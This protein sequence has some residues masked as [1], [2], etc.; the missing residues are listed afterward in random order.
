MQIPFGLYPLSRRYLIDLSARPHRNVATEKLVVQMVNIC[1]SLNSVLPCRVHRGDQCAVWCSIF[2]EPSPV[3]RPHGQD[4][5]CRRH[6]SSYVSQ[7]KAFPHPALTLHL[8]TR[9]V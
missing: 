2:R 7:H 5:P 4:I 3:G 1:V 8:Y 6:S 9:A